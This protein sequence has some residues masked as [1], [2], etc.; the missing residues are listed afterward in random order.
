MASRSDWDAKHRKAGDT[1]RNPDP[2]LADA[3]EYVRSAVPGAID[4]VDIA[5]GSGRHAIA[6]AAYGLK[7]VAVDYS[8]EGL[9]VC[10]RRAVEK[11]LAIET[12]C[13]D[14]ERSDVDLGEACFDVVAVFRY[15]HRPLVPLLKRIARPGGIV[16]YKTFTR[17][18]PRFGSGPRNPSYLLGE[19]ELPALFAD[20]RH[21]FYR[22][23]CDSEATAA[24]IAQRP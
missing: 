2:F 21:L 18:Q 6:L 1:D 3:L 24:L 16:I 22:E 14:L 9:R 19:N 23:T 20:F 8:A 7:T 11:G 13:L 5:C 17:E 12:R 10:A 15:L 4:A